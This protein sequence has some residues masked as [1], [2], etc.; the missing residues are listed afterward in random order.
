MDTN[1]KQIQL[2]H[3]YGDNPLIKSLKSKFLDLTIEKCSQTQINGNFNL[4]Q[5]YDQYIISSK[6]TYDNLIFTY[7][8]LKN[9]KH[10]N[11][12]KK[13]FYY[14]A[15]LP[16]DVIIKLN[17]SISFDELKKFNE[18]LLR[19]FSFPGNYF[20]TTLELKVSGENSTYVP[21]QFGRDSVI[22]KIKVDGII[23]ET[24]KVY[25]F[26]FNNKPFFAHK[27]GCE[28]PYSKQWND[29]P[30]DI[31]YL[32]SLNISESWKE[33]NYKFYPHQIEGIK[34][35]LHK[36]RACIF[37]KVGIG[38]SNQAIAAAILNGSK[39]VLIITIKDDVHKWRQL[40]QDF[41]QTACVIDA[42]FK[43][44]DELTD[45]SD[46]HVINY[47]I[48]KKY[49]GKNTAATEIFNIFKY[50]YETIIVDECHNIRNAAAKKSSIIKKLFS[51]KYVK[52][53]YALSAT[54]FETNDQ[55]YG[56][57]STMGIPIGDLLPKAGE[58]YEMMMRKYEHYKMRYCNGT[59]INKMINNRME[60]IIVIG[61]KVNGVVIPNSN[62]QELYQLIK[63]T[64]LCRTPDDVEG[65][66]KKDIH[67]LDLSLTPDIQSKYNAYR[68]ELLNQYEQM[69]VHAELPAAIKLRQFLS[70]V[71]VKQTAS[72]ARNLISTGEK[73]IIFTHYKE[74]FD[75]MCKELSDTSVWV[76]ADPSLR[77]KK[78]QNKDI[79]N[80]FK[81]SDKYK[82]LIGNA[83]TLGTGHNIPQATHVIINSPDWNSGEHS[84]MMGRNWRLDRKETVHAW[85]WIYKDT[86]CEEVFKKAQSKEDNVNI[87]LQNIDI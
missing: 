58:G 10:I 18:Y 6:K 66:P 56:L 14:T 47:D 76:N 16:D 50:R 22:D 63:G 80:L 38:K 70:L 39:K 24:S 12:G 74:E 41:G 81:T 59:Y 13:Y 34:F 73:V 51:Q 11:V 72:F 43:K 60:K 9:N 2:L 87:L 55:L 1:F 3:Y 28:N 69:D 23:G 15:K 25:H 44:N 75:E 79:V 77:Y 46:Y 86:K 53:V 31:D 54:P 83:Q 62:T 45:S 19:N 20:N 64:Y 42:T 29:T 65:F 30:L 17:E 71:A 57:Y 36:K 84:Q 27:D 5:I 21:K 7:N 37:D 40:A 48:I 61:K 32:N 33:N 35:L 82:I 68:D 52:N 49:S 85:F 26:I 78:M 8:E 4:T 67:V